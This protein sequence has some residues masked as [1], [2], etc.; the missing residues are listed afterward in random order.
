[1]LKSSRS[2]CP[3]AWLGNDAPA[4]R[5]RSPRSLLLLQGALHQ[6]R[7]RPYLWQTLEVYN[8]TYKSFAN[9]LQIRSAGDTINHAK[10]WEKKTLESRR[11]VALQQADLR[12][13]H[14][15]RLSG[16]ETQRFL[17]LRRISDDGLRSGPKTSGNHGLYDL[18]TAM[19]ID[20]SE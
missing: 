15:P 16:R 11:T 17:S 14:P 5:G 4:L 20:T 6:I 13:Q 3:V 7:T 2:A 19:K 1:M 10:L 12:K 18:T 9:A 8:C